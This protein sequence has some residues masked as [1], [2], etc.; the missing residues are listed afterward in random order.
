MCGE[1]AWWKH[2]ADVQTE[3]QNGQEGDLKHFSCDPVVGARLAG[4]SISKTADLM[5]FFLQYYLSGLERM[6]RK[7]EIYPVSSSFVA[8]NF[9]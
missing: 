4:L 3:H 5:G 2:L 1:S 9:L 6:V 7:R 8:G